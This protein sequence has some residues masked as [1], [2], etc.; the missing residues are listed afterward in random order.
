MRNSIPP[1]QKYGLGERMVT[2]S[3]A[4]TLADL[5][6][7]ST[8][9]GP[10]VTASGAQ[11]TQQTYAGGTLARGTMPGGTMPGTSS[12]GTGP[13]GTRAANDEA[14]V[15]E[16]NLT[17][18]PKTIGSNDATVM[19]RLDVAGAAPTSIEQKWDASSSQAE[20]TVLERQMAMAPPAKR[21]PPIALAAAAVA[22]LL[23]LAAVF[24]LRK[25]TAPPVA[26]AP[27]ATSG[28]QVTATSAAPMAPGEGVLLLSASPWGEIERIVSKG[29]QKE[30]PLQPDAL[31]TPTA[32]KLAAGDYL[33]TLSGEEG[34][35][36]IDVQIQAG[37]QTQ[38]N[39]RMRD[40]NFDELTQEV[41]KQ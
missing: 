37:K 24:L 41:T 34:T 13:T 35:Q 36:T 15:M 30:V 16:R 2:L 12:P 10:Q 25:P 28:T 23:A 38:K 17:A 21:K 1:D 6:M 29:D 39:V 40:L 26:E 22:I 9:S 18:S 20:A 4:Q 5:K 19:E 3:G 8:G 32:I 7:T 31:A 14:T 27:T 33:V 11:P